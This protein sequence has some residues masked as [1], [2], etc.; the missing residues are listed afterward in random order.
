M[1]IYRCRVLT[2]EGRISDLLRE[3]P[4][5]EILIRALN[6]EAIFPVEVRR[7]REEE[8]APAARRR[9]F[10][11]GSVL[12]FTSTMGML[13][14]SGLT[15]KDSL[16]IAQTIFLKGE[17]NQIIVSLLEEIQ[18]GRSVH[19]ALEPIAAGFPPIFRGFVRIGERIG[20]LDASFRQLAEYLGE[21]RRLK[22]RLA[23]S[24]VYPAMVLGVAVT[25][26]VG[27]VV[28]VFP[29][30]RE[31]FAELGSALPERLESMIDLLNVLLV[32]AVAVA[33]VAIVAVPLLAVM[34]RRSAAFAERLDRLALG[35]PVWGRVRYL[36]EALNLTFALETLTAGGLTVEDALQEAGAVVHNRALRSGVREARERVL[37]GDSLSRAFLDNPIFGE[38]VGRWIAVGE[39]SGQV[40]PVF[41]QLRRYYQGEIEK[42]STRFMSL[43]EPVLILL[44]GII[45]LLLILFFITPIFSIYEGLV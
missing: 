18:K 42:W 29:R 19:Q 14:S 31:M 38:R 37:K 7:V 10:S 3:A 8:V 36:Q 5:E 34:R 27:I 16:E 4:S 24:L 35:L 2:K 22:S 44:V 40:A 39:R 15:F 33:A 20:S 26:I 21:Q 32:A 25:G 23:G 13:L 12:E 41:G 28:F 30:I 17:V 6:R 45:I 11:A 9:R 43:V 1:S